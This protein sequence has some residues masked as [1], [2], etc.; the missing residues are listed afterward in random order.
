MG[1]SSR[2]NMPPIPPIPPSTSRLKKMLYCASYC[3][4][5]VLI[6]DAFVMRQKHYCSLSLSSLFVSVISLVVFLHLLLLPSPPIAHIHKRA[7]HKNYGRE[8]Q[9][10]VPMEGFVYFHFETE[11]D[12]DIKSTRS[13]YI[14]MLDAACCLWGGRKYKIC[15]HN[16]VTLYAN[17]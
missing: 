8:I 17:T 16:S 6:T 1:K 3:A 11:R 13:Y 14:V 9:K 15:I 12:A 10:N 2:P 5:K 4:L 7:L